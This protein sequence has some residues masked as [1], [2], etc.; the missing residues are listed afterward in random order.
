MAAG[1]GGWFGLGE[2]FGYSVLFGVTI[3]VRPGCR[4]V[5]WKGD[6]RL[7][8]R[9]SEVDADDLPGAPVAGVVSGPDTDLAVVR[10]RPGHG[11]AGRCRDRP[12][13]PRA[14]D[15]ATLDLVVAQPRRQDLQPA[16]GARP[17][18]RHACV[19]VVDGSLRDRPE[20]GHRARLVRLAD[21]H[22]GV[23]PDA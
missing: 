9:A 8:R 2:M 15:P 6:G 4:R 10:L 19:R 11:P 12:G 17:A 23:V 18:D 5:R 3:P 22:T 20:P 21:E 7:G 13:V 16:I 14:A 1:A